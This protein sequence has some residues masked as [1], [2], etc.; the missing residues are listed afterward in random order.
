VVNGEPSPRHGRQHHLTVE[1]EVSSALGR[2]TQRLVEMGYRHWLR[3]HGLD[4]I[5][6]GALRLAARKV[7][8]ERPHFGGKYSE[9]VIEAGMRTLEELNRPFPTV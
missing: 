4:V 9:D 7:L 5:V 2:R 6:Q 1:R 3:E 8:G